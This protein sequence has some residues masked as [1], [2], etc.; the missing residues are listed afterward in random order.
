SVAPPGQDGLTLWTGWMP[1]DPPQGWPKLRSKVEKAFVAHAAQYYDGIEQLEIGRWVADPT[2][3]NEAKSLRFGNVYQADLAPTRMGPLRP[4]LGFGGYKTP[5]PGYFIT[6]GGTH[7]GPSV[8]GIP[9]QQAARV[10][11]R[12]LAKDDRLRHPPTYGFATHVPAGEQESARAGN[13]RDS[14]AVAPR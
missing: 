4:A 1:W 5:V 11:A 7:P 13:G 3:I 9:G 6:G 12:A 10:V 8:S 14:G 2:E